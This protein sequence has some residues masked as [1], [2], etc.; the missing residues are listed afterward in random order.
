MKL[1]PVLLLLF[2]PIL[3]RG[4]QYEGFNEK[5]IKL[6]VTEFWPEMRY[7]LFNVSY[8][9]PIAVL[10]TGAH[11]DGLNISNEKG[12]L[13]KNTSA[14]SSL[15]SYES[16]TG[17]GMFAL[18]LFIR[19][20]AFPENGILQ[21]KGK[22]SVTCSRL[23]ALP[24]TE[25]DLRS[26]GSY[27]IPLM[28]PSFLD[29]EEDVASPEKCPHLK[30][31]VYPPQENGTWTIGLTHSVSFP[32]AGME[33]F[34]LQG[35]RISVKVEPAR[36]RSGSVEYNPFTCTF[37]G[38]YDCVR[39]RIQYAEKREKRNFPVHISITRKNTVKPSWLSVER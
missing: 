32:Y 9:A 23:S 2:S 25:I 18:G 27:S 39:I 19:D 36:C 5:T 26:Y 28:I 37:P 15:H 10:S 12:T 7:F 16:D 1:L 20:N 33:F 11:T 30:I 21:L 22:L 35:R 17:K 24:E 31:Q 14:G 29:A 6:Q 4:E 3:S 34:D 8:T 13:L 38:K